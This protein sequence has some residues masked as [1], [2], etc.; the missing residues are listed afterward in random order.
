M[1]SVSVNLLYPSRGYSLDSTRAPEVLRRLFD[2]VTIHAA[3]AL[4]DSHDH[5]LN[6]LD[7]KNPAER[8][9]LEQ[10]KRNYQTEG[11]AVS[12]S[13]TLGGC[14]ASGTVKQHY[15]DIGNEGVLTQ[16]LVDCFKK[17]V[18]EL[19]PRNCEVDFCETSD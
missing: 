12:F 4:R 11:P 16:D 18:M 13:V 1:P 15:A 9:V 6:V 8:T 3:D 17:F 19:L 10:L 14:H 7:A 5:A 2:Q